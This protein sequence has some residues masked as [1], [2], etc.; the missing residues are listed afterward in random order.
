MIY[1]YYKIYFITILLRKINRL[2]VD[3]MY[4]SLQ[5]L[6]NGISEFLANYTIL[7]PKSEVNMN[8][9][10][11]LLMDLC[12]RLRLTV[13]HPKFGESLLEE[14]NTLGQTFSHFVNNLLIIQVKVSNFDNTIFFQYSM[15]I[16]I[17]NLR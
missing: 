4:P 3:Q 12:D 14:I 15:F 5:T 2:A 7:L 6:I 8:D 1:Y 16:I 9:D 13:R 10:L 11:I 17:Y